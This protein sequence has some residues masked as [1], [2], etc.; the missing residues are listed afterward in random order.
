M[1]LEQLYRNEWI[2]KKEKY[3]FFLS[4]VYTLIALFLSMIL[5]EDYALTAIFFTVILIMNSLNKLLDKEETKIENEPNFKISTLYKEHKEIFKLYLFIFLGIFSAFALFTLI[6]PKLI[7]SSMFQNNILLEQ[8]K[9]FTY[10]LSFISNLKLFLIGFALSFFYGTGGMFL[11]TLNAAVWGTAFGAILKSSY[12]AV[13][14][15]FIYFFSIILVLLPYFIFEVIAFLS[16][17]IAGGVLSKGAH[18]EHITSQKFKKIII[19]ALIMF[20]LA[21]L[22]LLASS[23][24][25]KYFTSV[26][27]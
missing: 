19:D 25:N 1:V 22:L 11:I 9:V 17:T 10:S 18:N 24:V 21:L 7:T 26:L 6:W 13:S 2:N 14:N 8:G 20:S 3:A 15:P 27:L 12:F 23:I 16:V 4:S 5:F